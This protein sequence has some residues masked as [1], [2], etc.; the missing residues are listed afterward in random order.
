MIMDFV[1][2]TSNDA[3]SLGFTPQASQ[4]DEDESPFES[5]DGQG[6]AAGSENHDF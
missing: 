5:N 6:A 1:E 4:Y 2:Y 3:E